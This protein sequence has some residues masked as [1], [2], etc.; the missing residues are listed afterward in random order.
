MAGHTYY[1]DPQNGNDSNSGLTEN[2]P[3]KTHTRR[4]FAP[5]DTILFKR[6]TVCREGLFACNGSDQE[7]ITY[8]AYGMGKKP[9]FLG[10]VPANEP[11]RWIE[12]QPNLWRY[13]GV[14]PSEVCS[15]VF[16]GGQSFGIFR[17]QMTDLKEQGEWHYTAIGASGDL[18]DPLSEI[19][20]IPHCEDGALYLYSSRNPAQY[21]SEIEC[22]LWGHRRLVSGQRYIIF[23][24][25]SFENSGVHGYMDV[26]TDH[27]LIRNCDFRYI[28]GGVWS[29][30]HRIRFGNAVEFWDGAKDC[31]VE[32]CVFENIFDA[33]VTHQ[34]SPESE[35]PER[36]F[37]RNNFFIHCGIA[38][39]ECRGPAAKDIYFENNTCVHAGGEFSLQGEPTRQSEFYPYPISHHVFI[40]MIEWADRMGPVYI[41][42]NI[43]YQT[44]LGAAIYS[45]IPP[46][47]EQHLVIDHNC[48]WQTKGNILCRLNGKDYPPGDWSL[49]QKECRQ[50]MHSVLADPKFVNPDVS[51]YRL[52]KDSPCPTAGRKPHR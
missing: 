51:D 13:T 19:E 52:Q 41:R 15:L 1:I 26:R 42:N 20:R 17:W 38:A 25:L 23:E 2:Q 9:A 39:Y 28:G 43:F 46:K 32:D 50:D 31:V 6:G 4:S 22:S 24:N 8:G 29:K 7:Y 49:Y 16:N 45:I 18:H 30:K 12:D 36:I 27:I 37:F 14:F 47:D 3:L 40:W 44:P 10:S 35:V 5:G 33:G 48:Y 34:G 11:D 21:Y